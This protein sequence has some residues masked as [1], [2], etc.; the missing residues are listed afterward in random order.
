M[1]EKK[2]LT[3]RRKIEIIYLLCGT[4]LFGAIFFIGSNSY[5]KKYMELQ[6]FDVQCTLPREVYNSAENDVLLTDHMYYIENKEQKYYIYSSNLNYFNEE[7]KKIG[8]IHNPSA[9]E[10]VKDTYNVYE[11]ANAIESFTGFPVS[12]GTMDSM[13]RVSS[14]G[15]YL[16]YFQAMYKNCNYEGRASIFWSD[17]NNILLT[18]VL[19]QDKSLSEKEIGTILC[20]HGYAIHK[21]N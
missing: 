18:I 16:Y 14:Y 9:V 3:R 7:D 19:F 8:F 4:V 2:L 15:T 5:R 6:F 12:E 1:K 20:N 21:K 17:N 10:E 11:G 13:Q